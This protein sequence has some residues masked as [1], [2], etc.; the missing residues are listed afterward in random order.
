LRAEKSDQLLPPLGKRVAAGVAD[1]DDYQLR[2]EILARHGR[3]DEAQSDFEKSTELRG[4]DVVRSLAG[5]WWVVGP[6]PEELSATC[7]PE[8]NPNP[9]R[10]VASADGQTTLEWAS[11]LLNRNGGLDLSRQFE[12]GEHMS[13]YA[14]TRVFCSGPQ[15][16]GL[17]LGSDDLHRLWVNGRLVHQN[18]R[19]RIAVPDQD[20]VIVTLQTG[21]NDVLVKVTNITGGY[22]LYLRLCDDP[23]QLARVFEKNLQFGEALAQWNRAVEQV[24]GDAS[25]IAQRSRTE[26]L[27]GRLDLALA[28]VTSLLQENA[29]NVGMLGYRAQLYA[30]QDRW[31]EA[32][33]DSATMEALY[34]ND[35]EIKFVRG[36][37]HA[38][39]GETTAIR[40]TSQWRWLHP[41]NG[42]DPAEEYPQFHTRFAALDVEDSA[43]GVGQDS[44]G[45]VGGFG[46]D[47]RGGVVSRFSVAIGA[48]AGGVQTTAYFRHRF[49]SEVEL[50]D[51]Y[52]QMQRKDGVIIYLDGVE[53]G[54]D[55]M[56]ASEAFQSR[57][58]TDI[59]IENHTRPVTIHLPGT[60]PPGE[61]VMAIS[62][63]S[64][65][66]A[67]N[68]MRIGEIS[69]RG[70][71]VG[72]ETLT[73][74]KPSELFARGL[75]F[76]ELNQPE[77]GEADFAR[78][79]ELLGGAGVES[80]DKL[81]EA[82]VRVASVYSDKNDL[83]FALKVLNLAV[84][85]D[86]GNA[87]AH[88]L[89]GRLLARQRKWNSAADELSRAVERAPDDHWIWVGL[90]PIL[91]E[92][93]QR[94]RY[95]QH[96]AQLVQRFAAAD[97]ISAGQIIQS[98][99]W[100]PDAVT[101]WQALID[102]LKATIDEMP[103][104]Q[105]ATRLAGL[106]LLEYRAG[107]P[108]AAIDL[109]TSGI[110]SL[111]DA[112]KAMSLAM[113]A[114]AYHDA[115]R[116]AEAE[117]TLKRT[118]ELLNSYFVP[119][120]TDL[121]NAWHDWL[122]ARI[123]R[124]EA[125]ER[126]R[127][128]GSRWLVE[129]EEL[130]RDGRFDEAYERLARPEIEQV[131]GPR[132]AVLRANVSA[133]RGDWRN[134]AA[135]YDRA[136][137][138]SHEDTIVWMRGAALLAESKDREAYRAY[139]TRMLAQFAATDQPEFAERVAKASLLLAPI[140]HEM[141]GALELADKSLTINPSHWVIPWAQPVKGL[142]E[143]HRGNYQNAIDWAQKSLDGPER[144]WYRDA[145]SH[146]VKALAQKQLGHDEPAQKSLAE[147]K[148]LI[149][150]KTKQVERDGIDVDWHDWVIDRILLREAETLIQ[151]NKR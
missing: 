24:P 65:N 47:S 26:R 32:L 95:R 118:E 13:C 139:C 36:R 93:G 52:V 16:T 87:N 120:R 5:P 33:A 141:V 39:Y 119:S 121:G 17:L 64:S 114:M 20:A 44:P 94:D 19:P 53:V 43:W 112:G 10:S 125:V 71:P 35:W 80:N 55:N 6:Y 60:L 45:A 137:K 86:R 126:I 89:R 128:T 148:V 61:H 142:A 62:L 11:A 49:R 138:L 136:A 18:L 48:P 90:A 146:L 150:V 73:L 72:Q 116:T 143:Y 3:W 151:H 134:A 51:L 117:S 135:E 56:T 123:V 15:Q 122:A 99:L 75:A 127:G 140:P 21:W 97:A 96:C 110:E 74:E 54:R 100:L 82:L 22:G 109:L 98:C 79:Y 107:R 70:R 9:L 8:T 147:A 104:W 4:D 144:L 42:R 106:G 57:A 78:A 46:F 92:I 31:D 133:R 28:D 88:H 131:A 38:H 23:I 103:A 111:D 25:L 59:P 124:R 129:A 84:M 102:T 145:L 91:V 69:L 2:G 37:L 63:H 76:L 34:P 115:G 29:E 132:V 101:D 41:A 105:R 40:P 85:A 7:P 50:A 67:N 66:S 68:M 14:Y 113:F 83:T 1:A 77:A 27:S 58:L 81:S 30:E 130:E 12:R 108:E 149:D